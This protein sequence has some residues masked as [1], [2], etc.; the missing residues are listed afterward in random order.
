MDFSRREILGTISV[1]FTTGRLQ[2]DKQR[3]PWGV[4]RIHAPKAHKQGITGKGVDIA[5]IDSGVDLDHPDLQENLGEGRAFVEYRDT[6]NWSD[7]NGHGTHS[8]GIIAGVDNDK[9]ILGVAPEATIHPVKVLNDDLSFRDQDFVAGTKWAADQG[10]DIINM[11]LGGTSTSAK[12]TAIAYATRKG[13]ILVAS[14]GNEGCDCVDA[15][16]AYDSVLAVTAVNRNDKM[17]TKSSV[18][19]SVD[20]TA[21]GTDILSTFPGGYRRLSG[22]SQA[23][24]H[25]SGALGLLLSHEYSRDN[26][27]TRL[28]STTKDVGLKSP[29]QGT[30]LID[31]SAALNLNSDGDASSNSE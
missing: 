29:Q 28:L 14:V 24:P 21:P 9:G 20:V 23:A 15:P 13:S 18:G 17:Y 8:A 16:A 5:V 6:S 3:I 30:G 4:K 12:R 22:T 11:S 25:A 26:A 2:T 31:V 10:Y 1:G 7:D 19:F 27:L